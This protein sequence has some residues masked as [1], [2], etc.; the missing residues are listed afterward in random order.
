MILPC[1]I[2]LD[3]G[4]TATYPFPGLTFFQK[5]DIV[6]DHLVFLAIGISA[7]VVLMAGVHALAEDW[8]LIM[9]TFAGSVLGV[10]LQG[11]LFPVAPGS[12]NVFAIGCIIGGLWGAFSPTIVDLASFRW[13]QKRT[14][15]RKN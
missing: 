13:R 5:E 9:G 6:H 1:G 11:T 15:Y 10:F 7:V 14:L 12:E 8:G 4:D 2:C 3:F